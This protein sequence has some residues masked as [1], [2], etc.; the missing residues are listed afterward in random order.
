MIDKKEE[1]PRWQSRFVRLAA[2]P[3]P[4]RDTKKKAFFTAVSP[5]LRVDSASVAV[6]KS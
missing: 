4:A 5:V 1:V 6:V 2:A 3:L